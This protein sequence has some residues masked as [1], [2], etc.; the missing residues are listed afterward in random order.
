MRRLVREY[1]TALP[2]RQT[3]LALTNALPQ[4][5]WMGEV[6]A[7]HSFVR[8][9]IR[10]V[11]DINGVETVQTPLRTLENEAGDCDDKSLLVATLL[12]T[13]GFPTRFVAMAFSPGKYSHVLP[14]VKV[15]RRWI[16]LETTERRRFGWY[17]P[18]PHHRMVVSNR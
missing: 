15:G 10:Y 4:K 9:N 16:P 12:E 18:K 7:L 5:D 6:R 14:E 11:R 13:I 17:P 1:K 2:I 8:D 3:A